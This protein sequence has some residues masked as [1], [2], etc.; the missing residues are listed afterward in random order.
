MIGG[1][2]FMEKVV[3]FGKGGKIW[4]GYGWVETLVAFKRLRGSGIVSLNTW[5]KPPHKEQWHFNSTLYYNHNDLANYCDLARN[6]SRL[7]FSFRMT[8]FVR[9]INNCHAMGTAGNTTPI[10]FVARYCVIIFGTFA[11]LRLV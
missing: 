5:R 8:L 10:T 3:K 11:S 9:F 7:A 2:E 4:K 6:I 1:I